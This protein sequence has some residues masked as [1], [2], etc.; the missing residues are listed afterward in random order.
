M[1][2]FEKSQNRRTAE[3]KI[4][5]LVEVYEFSFPGIAKLQKQ[6]RE[7]DECVGMYFAAESQNRKNRKELKK[8]MN[9]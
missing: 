4:G 7:T 2:D 3:T 1:R 8:L 5:K 6:I 9:T